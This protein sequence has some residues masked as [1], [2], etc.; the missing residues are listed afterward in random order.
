MNESENACEKHHHRNAQ[1]G[2]GEP[3]YCA[4]RCLFGR[5]LAHSSFLVRCLAPPTCSIERSFSTPHAALPL[6]VLKRGMGIFLAFHTE[7][8]NRSNTLPYC[9][10]LCGIKQKQ[11]STRGE[12]LWYHQGVTVFCGACARGANAMGSTHRK[13]E[14]TPIRQARR[15][16][17]DPVLATWDIRSGNRHG[18]CD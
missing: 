18:A 5:W 3:L 4:S 8:A 1:Q 16:L 17:I 14:N 2:N 12:R 11:T 13:R 7:L 15:S 10:Q 9:T 6:P